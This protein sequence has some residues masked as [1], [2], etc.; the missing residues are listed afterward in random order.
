MKSPSSFSRRGP[1]RVSEELA[2][3]LSGATS[4][5]FKSLFAIVHANLKARNA[6]SGG[7]EMLRLRAYD[8]LQNFVKAGVVEKVGK[9]Y[10]GVAAPLANYIKT[11]TAMNVEFDTRKFNRVR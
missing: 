7:E 5:D 1:D 2:S 3:A 9:E 6:V 10:R 11:S 8:K 4:F